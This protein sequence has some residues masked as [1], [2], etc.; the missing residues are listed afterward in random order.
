MD[1][2]LKKTAEIKKSAPLFTKKQLISSKKYSDRK[3]A[4]N[5]L[6][7]ENKT[8]TIEETDKILTDFMKGRQN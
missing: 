3:D 8:Y 1:D 6:L 4:I 7:S 5:A 2:K